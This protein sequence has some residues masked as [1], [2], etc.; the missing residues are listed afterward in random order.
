[1]QHLPLTRF[2]RSL[3]SLKIQLYARHAGADFR[4]TATGTGLTYQWQ[5]NKGTGFN[6]VVDDANFSGSNLNTLTIT[7]AQA[8]FNNYIF[9][10]IVSGYMR[11][12]CLL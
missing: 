6:N 10:I 8:A 2:L 9:R 3:C 12:S 11:Y 7:N 1:M 5:V 4:I